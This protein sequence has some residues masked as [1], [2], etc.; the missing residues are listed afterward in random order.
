[1]RCTGLSSAIGLICAI[2][3]LATPCS[4]HAEPLDMALVGTVTSAPD[5]RMEGVLVS[6]RKQGSNITIT[7][8]SDAQGHYGFPAAKLNPGQYSLSVRAVGY[9]LAAPETAEVVTEQTAT[10][11]LLLRRA[12]DLAAQLT[13]GEWIS[14]VP[15]TDAQKTALLNC[16]GCHTLERIVR[17][18]HTADEFMAVLERMHGYVNQS[19][20]SHPQLRHADRLMEEQSDQR[21]EVQRSL[22]E[23]LAT[24][25]LS[26]T[27]KWSYPLKTL[28]R[29]SG[30]ATHV[31]IT[32]Y[33]LPRETIEPHDVIVDAD[34]MVWYSSFG[35][36]NL[37]RLDPRSGRVTE[38]PLPEL[39][40]GFPTGS[41]G[42]R[43]D[44]AGNLWLGLMY[45]GG[46]ARFDKQTEAFRIWPLPAAANIDAAQVNMVSP[47]SSQVDGK[48]WTQ[49]NGFAGVHRLDIA[50]GSIE[51][52]QPFRQAPKGEP[53]NI[54]DVIPDSQNNAYFTDFRQQHIGRIDAKTGQVTL[55]ATPTPRSAP[56]RGM[57]DAQD[58]LWFGEFRGN[59]I[60]MFNT[61]TGEFTEWLA[62]TPWTAPYDVTLDKNGEAWTGS[63]TTDRV[64]RLDTKTGQ[65]VEYLLPLETNIRRV[66][67]DNGTSPV[68]FWVGSNHGASIVKLEPLD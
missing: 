22:A 49:N 51:T 9:E 4:T 66:F 16:T 15:G 56:R 27:P 34:G 23:Y 1:M 41:L 57:M 44:P 10:R 21:V 36:P 65:F 68:T 2:F 32:E 24:I 13:N 6:A 14:S 47:Q 59:R 39:K 5:A 46:I 58:R 50:S 62:P 8:V 35:E 29:P 43:M 33:D 61:K 42:L 40:P 67:V 25:N 19:I 7:V 52:F 31:V 30:R 3:L 45:Q 53:H 38:Y 37:G 26:T 18:D 54:Y 11:D 48:V 55:F 60:G 12:K 63:M 28:P 64:L 17:S 20:P